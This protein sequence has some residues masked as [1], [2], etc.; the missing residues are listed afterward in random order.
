[1]W[2]DAKPDNLLVFVDERRAVGL[3]AKLSDFSICETKFTLQ[4][5]FRSFTWPWAAS[6]VGLKTRLDLA[7][8]STT[9]FEE[10]VRA[11]VYAFGMLIWM[12]AMD[13]C[14]FQPSLQVETGVGFMHLGIWLMLDL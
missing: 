3:V 11:E 10:M 2:G 8:L 5:Q 1:M 14:E 13:I 9:G 7:P 6:G 12:I 4:M